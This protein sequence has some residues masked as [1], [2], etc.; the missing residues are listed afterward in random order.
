M[1]N[2]D[3][4]LSRKN[5]GVGC[6]IYGRDRLRVALVVREILNELGL[7]WYLES[8]TLLGALRNQKFIPHDDDFDIA[9]LM[10]TQD[11]WADLTELYQQV[12]ERLPVPLDCR[13][14]NTYTDKIEV[15]DPAFGK[16]T[17]Q[18]P[19]YKGAD[20]H[21]VTVDL[22]PMVVNEETATVHSPY[23]GKPFELRW[24]LDSVLPLSTIILEGEEFL[25]PSD[26]KRFLEGEY[27]G[28][29]PGAIYDEI[30]GKYRSPEIRESE[31]C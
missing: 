10:Y 1:E 6:D 17:L 14:V 19:S 27:G 22:Q 18:H 4:T 15:Y 12:K 25:C 28:I 29:E 13:I 5:A 20:F 3:Q 9:F 24:D 31:K 21:C 2:T 11:F 16:F 8:G 26:P 23:R 30:T 7:A